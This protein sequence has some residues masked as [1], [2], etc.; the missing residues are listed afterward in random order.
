VEKA[1][2]LLTLSY[3]QVFVAASHFIWAFWHSA[4]VFGAAS[5]GDTKLI[6]SPKATSVVT[7]LLIRKSPV[8]AT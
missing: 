5:V 8:I 4:F 1:A 6:A 7:S 2:L 3:E